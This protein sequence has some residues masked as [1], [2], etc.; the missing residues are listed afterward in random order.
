MREVVRQYLDSLENVDGWLQPGAAELICN[1]DSLQRQRGI[2]GARVEFGVHHGRSLILLA[3]LDSES[4]VLGLDLD[5]T[6]VSKNIASYGLA[7]VSMLLGNTN[8]VNAKRI[9]AE[10]EALGASSVRMISVDG[11]HTYEGTLHDL[12]TTA[13]LLCAGGVTIVDDVANPIYPGVHRAMTEVIDAEHLVPFAAAGGRI[14]MCAPADIS[15]WADALVGRAVVDVRGWPVVMTTD[16]AWREPTLETRALAEGVTMDAILLPARREYAREL[17]ATFAGGKVTGNA[18]LEYWI[19][20][21][22]RDTGLSREELGSVAKEVLGDEGL[23]NL[24][25]KWGYEEGQA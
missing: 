16:D 9:R 24:K 14:A 5:D 10:L 7:N 15:Q 12:L 20:E 22:M 13:E 11:D 23:E 18:S 4:V 1:L 19:G 2:A 21:F 17:V 6:H 25:R 8:D 3:L